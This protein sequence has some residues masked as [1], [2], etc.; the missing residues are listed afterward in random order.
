M[1][2]L[3]HRPHS[4]L[5]WRR[6]GAGSARRPDPRSG[7]ASR[8]GLACLIAFVTIQ[9]LLIAHQPT[10]DCQLPGGNSA[11]SL[12]R[13]S[14]AGRAGVE[15]LSS[16]HSAEPQARQ[17]FESPNSDSEP[18]QAKSE[19]SSSSS[20]PPHRTGE[21]VISSAASRTDVAR[22]CWLARPGQDADPRTGG[23]RGGSQSAL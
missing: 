4:E 21:C 14:A 11:G 10:V 15:R 8:K 9:S 3:A 23:P 13:V 7:M 1:V 16:D 5:D 20:E 22:R 18:S 17:V 6:T 2:R 19:S 12:Y